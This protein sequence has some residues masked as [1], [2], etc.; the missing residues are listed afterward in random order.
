[1]H[2]F[3]VPCLLGLEKLVGDEIRR[4]GLKDV[5]VE[6][7]VAKLNF[8]KEFMQIVNNIDGGR[9]A[10]KALVVTCTQFEG[11]DSVEI[12]VEGE[13]WDAGEGVLTAP[14][15]S[16]VATEIESAAIQA[17]SDAIFEGE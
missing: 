16:N 11:V 8:T 2:T 15:F 12:Y 1:M 9:L 3:M 4:L 6:N 14:T 5:Q 7:G 13:K 17:Q 10:L